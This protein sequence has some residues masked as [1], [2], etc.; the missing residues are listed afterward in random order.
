MTTAQ[1]L[2]KFVQP[3]FSPSQP[4]L[5]GDLSGVFGARV[6]PAQ[7]AEG[8]LGQEGLGTAAYR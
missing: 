5:E 1:C 7:E 4:E 6:H 8:D 2:T 3:F